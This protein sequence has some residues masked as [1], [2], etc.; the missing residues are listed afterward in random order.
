MSQSHACTKCPQIKCCLHWHNC[1]LT[2]MNPHILVSN[3]GL[4]LGM[5]ELLIEPAADAP[6]LL[7]GLLPLGEAEWSPAPLVRLLGGDG[8]RNT[9]R[10]CSFFTSSFGSLTGTGGAASISFL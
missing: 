5:G 8:F 4:G 1:C 10:R 2:R 6:R 7:G 9:M 3:Q